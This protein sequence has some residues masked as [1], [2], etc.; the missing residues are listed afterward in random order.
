MWCWQNFGKQF[1]R[2]VGY[3]RGY[4]L[5]SSHKINTIGVFKCL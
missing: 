3:T 4:S 5:D 2:N 1:V